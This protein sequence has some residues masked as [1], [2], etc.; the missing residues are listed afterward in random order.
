MGRPRHIL[1]PH[2]D[3]RSLSRRWLDVNGGTGLV[4][5]R[6]SVTKGQWGGA[7]RRY[8]RLRMSHSCNIFPPYDRLELHGW[9]LGHG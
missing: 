3:R 1:D 7:Y 8:R 5:L 2:I 4:A 6:E 9:R